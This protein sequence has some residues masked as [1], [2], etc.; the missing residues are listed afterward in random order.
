MAL[1]PNSA[2][3]PY[4]TPGDFL[5]RKDVS[6]VAAL[7]VDAQ[8]VGSTPPS[9][10]ALAT[11]PTVAA[12]LASASGEVEAAATKGGKYL[13]SDLQAL[14]GNSLEYLK[15]LVAAI[16]FE[17]LREKRGSEFPPL[18]DYDRAQKALESIE[19][20]KAVFAFAEVEQAGLPTSGVMDAFDLSSQPRPSNLVRAFGVRGTRGGNPGYGPGG[21]Y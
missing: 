6:A 1:T 20:G 11:D 19:D 13:P 15:S 14:T 12:A 21:F 3:A 5:L 8:D 4:L 16:A 18:P 10:S 2:S 9:A 17:R 7:V